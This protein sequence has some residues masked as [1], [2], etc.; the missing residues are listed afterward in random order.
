MAYPGS[1]SPP[2]DILQELGQ[3]YTN[4]LALLDAPAA[5]QRLI[6]HVPEL[7]GVE[8]AFIGE[9]DGHGQMVLHRPVNLSERVEG[10]AAPMAASLGG[11]V[12][13]RH[14]PLWTSDYRNTPGITARFKTQAQAEGLVAIL[15]VPMIHDGRMLGVLYAGNRRQTDFADRTIQAL[16]NAAAR[17]V[18]AQIVA[19]RARHAAE[20]A[21]HEERHRLALDLHDSVGAM[22]FT[23]RAGIQ[24]LSDTPELDTAV[25]AR[26]SAIEQQAAQASAAL[27]GSLRVLHAPPQQVALGVALRGHC[28]AFSDRTGIRAQMIVLNELPA[29]ACA[30]IV[31]LADTAREA[32]LNVEKHACA[33]H[34]VV[35]AFADEDGVSVTVS[36]DGVGLDHDDRRDGGLGL[37]S[38]SERISR[39]GGTLRIGPNEDNGTGVTVQA[40]VPM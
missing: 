37:T 18:T 32:L 8:T 21:V 40:W 7:A 36:D 5:I 4:I 1:L 13:V 16:E 38:M 12:M 28:R 27:R 25:H 35:T 10:L 30:R 14:C 22:L 9:A 33:R 6:V 20:V 15:A 29:L 11:Q 2:P 39:V 17:M 24:Q 26:L 34:V 3:E 31:A 19:E 23:L